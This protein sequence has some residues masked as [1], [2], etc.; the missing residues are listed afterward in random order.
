MELT[1][2]NCAG[3]FEIDEG[4]VGSDGGS[5][6]CPMCGQAQDF[7]PRE[8]LEASIPSPGPAIQEVSSP[9][10]DDET[11]PPE[12]GAS[13]F[14]KPMQ[15]FSSFARR[16]V[17]GPD[18]MKDDTGPMKQVRRSYHEDTPFE[19]RI[20][21]IE[22]KEPS[23]PIPE[24]TVDDG[25]GTGLWL[26]KSPS[27]LVLEFPSS[28]LL[29]NWSAI[30]ENPAPYT[31]SKGGEVWQAMADFLEEVRQGN[32]G[33]SAFRRIANNLE[34]SQSSTVSVRSDIGGTD[35]MPM[36]GEAA[37]GAGED[38]VGPGEE[39]DPSIPTSPTSGFQFK[40]RESREPKSRK[41]LVVGIVVGVVVLAAGA[42]AALYFTGM[43]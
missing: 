39:D 43:I 9:P 3:T 38:D 20:P 40:I 16:Q 26:V 4:G 28:H 6:E 8:G 22:K 31:V 33:T 21:R 1:C 14:K 32:R 18:E 41:W 35:K 23:G 19:A 42:A 2:L 36:V 15:A 25:N 29:V 7:T 27:G 24:A 34:R 30:V 10:P 5:V 13:S 11:A 12:A 37:T 17:S